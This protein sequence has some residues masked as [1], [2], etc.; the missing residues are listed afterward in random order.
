MAATNTQMQAQLCKLADKVKSQKDL[1]VR[2]GNQAQAQMNPNK[3]E[4]D[5]QQKWQDFNYV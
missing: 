2:S 1:T 3:A 4:G 5:V